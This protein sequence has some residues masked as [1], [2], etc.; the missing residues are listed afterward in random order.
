[1]ITKTKFSSGSRVAVNLARYIERGTEEN[2]IY[3]RLYYG[4]IP[5]RDEDM[6]ELKKHSGRSNRHRPGVRHI[7]IAPERV[8]EEREFHILVL[9][10]M[11]RWI[12]KT[13][14]YGIR[15]VWGCTTT[16]SIHTHI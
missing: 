4:F 9:T 11:D 6:E 13:G 1:M 5:F 2:G 10:L 14:N 7:I 15:Y 16:R 12:R 8:L 3:D